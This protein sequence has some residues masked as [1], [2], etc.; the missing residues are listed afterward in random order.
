MNHTSFGY[1]REYIG[2]STELSKTFGFSRIRMSVCYKS[3][4]SLIYKP[5]MSSEETDQQGSVSARE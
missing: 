1:T 5:D 4:K 2:D 3:A